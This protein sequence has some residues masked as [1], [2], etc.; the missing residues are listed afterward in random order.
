MM[1]PMP[2]FAAVALLHPP[3]RD[4]RVNHLHQPS[5]ALHE[6]HSHAGTPFC[7]SHGRLPA[8]KRVSL[9][10]PLVTPPSQRPQEQSSMHPGTVFVPPSKGALARPGMTEPPSQPPQTRYPQCQ[11]SL[12]RPILRPRLLRQS[13]RGTPVEALPHHAVLEYCGGTPASYRYRSRVQPAWVTT[14]TV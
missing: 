5:Q 11:R 6:R 7:R 14:C 13:S 2:C 4:A 12:L 9:T 1:A 3:S 10:D 8:A